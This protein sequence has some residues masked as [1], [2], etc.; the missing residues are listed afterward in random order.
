[1]LDTVGFSGK[2]E[3]SLEQGGVCQEWMRCEGDTLDQQG[4]SWT[5][6]SAWNSDQTPQFWQSAS[7]SFPS[8]GIGGQACC[9]YQ[10]LI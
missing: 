4:P 5:S 9:M 8:F 3:A 7:A 2:R 1:M 6:F 10:D